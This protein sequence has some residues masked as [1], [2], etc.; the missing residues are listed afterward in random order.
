MRL[1]QLPC[2][3][4]QVVRLFART[5][6]MDEEIRYRSRQDEYPEEGP[7]KDWERVAAKAWSEITGILTT[8]PPFEA[9]LR[10]LL[11]YGT[12]TCCNW[13]TVPVRDR[14]LAARL[15]H[16]EMNGYYPHVRFLYREGGKA[17][18]CVVGK[19]LYCSDLPICLWDKEQNIYGDDLAR[20]P[21]LTKRLRTWLETA[22]FDYFKPAIPASNSQPEKTFFGVAMA[23]IAWFSLGI[24]RLATG[25]AE[26]YESKTVLKNIHKKS[27]FRPVVIASP[28][29]FRR[30]LASK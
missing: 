25:A 10:A 7:F 27:T 6:D 26:A 8:R 14:D 24:A 20:F 19:A 9:R 11:P 29:R 21:G 22:A 1:T 28:K 5:V 15:I 18:L 17:M 13:M 2:R 30:V 12:V 16:L 3:R 4:P 23:G